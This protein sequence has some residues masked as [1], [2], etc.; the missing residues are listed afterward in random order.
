[1]HCVVSFVQ[2]EK[3][4]KHSWRSVTFSKVDS[5]IMMTLF[6]EN[7]YRLLAVHYFTK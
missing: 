5:N 4:E 1:M 6:C 7:S 2:F 3:L